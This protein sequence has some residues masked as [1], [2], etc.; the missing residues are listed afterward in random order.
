[1]SSTGQVAYFAGRVACADA[2]TRAANPYDPEDP[3]HEEWLKGWHD[4]YKAL[5]EPLRA[6]RDAKEAA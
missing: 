3:A 2:K 5:P 4:E 6:V 1:M